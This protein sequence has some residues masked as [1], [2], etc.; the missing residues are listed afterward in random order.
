M[1]ANVFKLN[2]TGTAAISHYTAVPP[3]QHYRLVSAT[4]N[5]AAAPTT[6]ENLTITLYAAAGGIYGTLLYSLDLAAGSTTDLVWM[7]D[8]ELIFEGN[9]SIAMEWANS[10]TIN[11]GAQFTFKAV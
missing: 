1:S 7:P 5:L 8:E 2:A 6:S 10:D 9:D 4:L 11:Y 3:R